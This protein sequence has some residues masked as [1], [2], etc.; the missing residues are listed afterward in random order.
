MSG[1]SQTAVWQIKTQEPWLR[2]R[3][4]EK[5]I[6]LMNQHDVGGTK[7]QTELTQWKITRCEKT[8]HWDLVP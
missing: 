8:Y 2:A 4:N 1:P 7:K 6:T 3:E 5:K